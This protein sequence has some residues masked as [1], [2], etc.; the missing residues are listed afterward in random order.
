MGI[1]MLGQ[2]H[3]HTL[4]AIPTAMS[5]STQLKFIC[6]NPSFLETQCYRC[7]PSWM[8][9]LQYPVVYWH[10]L[11]PH[12]PCHVCCWLPYCQPCFHLFRLISC[13]HQPLGESVRDKVYVFGGSPCPIMTM[14][15][16]APLCAS[17]LTSAV[18]FLL[19]IIFKKEYF[20]L[21]LH[22]FATIYSLTLCMEENTAEEYNCI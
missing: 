18:L 19:K 21:F 10:I 9:F 16:L 11:T 15:A 1:P 17:C 6:P 5:S 3:C 8:L 7:S 14:G 20:F 12:A 2:L 22:S 13:H 4:E